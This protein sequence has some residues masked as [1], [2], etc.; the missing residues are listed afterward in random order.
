[1]QLEVVG[2]IELDPDD[3]G[4]TS[5]SS[6]SIKETRQSGTQKE[7]CVIQNA[8]TRIER[9]EADKMIPFGE[10]EASRFQECM[11][12]LGRLQVCRSKEQN[13]L[14]PRVLSSG[15]TGLLIVCLTI[16]AV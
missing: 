11:A 16:F 4:S 8:I 7:L 15:V 5:G 14:I 9:T 2:K 13:F 1:M 6:T 3:H 12:R 10:G